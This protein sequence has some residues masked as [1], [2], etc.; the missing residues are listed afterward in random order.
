MNSSLLRSIQYRSLLNTFVLCYSMSHTDSVIVFLKKL[1]DMER[2]SLLRHCNSRHVLRSSGVNNSN[3]RHVAGWKQ[4]TV[5][6]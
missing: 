4:T 1:E 3:T 5:T 2:G 6:Q